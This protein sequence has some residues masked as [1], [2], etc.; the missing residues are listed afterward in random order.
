MLDELLLAASHA[1]WLLKQATEFTLSTPDTPAPGHQQV[2]VRPCPV[3]PVDRT[4]RPVRVIRRGDRWAVWLGEFAL[5][6]DGCFWDATPGT[7]PT[8]PRDE[9]IAR[10]IQALG[11]L[12]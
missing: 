10:A 11:R 9:A 8:Y 5:H 12:P 3:R 2:Q 4:A 1:R 6:P 7:D